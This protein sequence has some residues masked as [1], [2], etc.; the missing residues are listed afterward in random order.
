MHTH[1]LQIV[2]TLHTLTLL[3]LKKQIKT[4][5]DDRINGTE[6]TIKEL[7]LLYVLCSKNGKISSDSEATIELTYYTT[8]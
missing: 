4:H 2:M 8:Y 3:T 1:S 6:N 5:F 7:S